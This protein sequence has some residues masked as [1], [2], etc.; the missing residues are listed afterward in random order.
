MKNRKLLVLALPLL[1]LAACN[2]TPGADDGGTSNAASDS[3]DTGDTGVSGDV[4]DSGEEVVYTFQDV[5]DAVKGNDFDSKVNTWSKSRVSEEA[6][7]TY[8]LGDDYASYNTSTQTYELD[9]KVYTNDVD[10]YTYI[11]DGQ[12]ISCLD[13]IRDDYYLQFE[14]TVDGIYIPSAYNGLLVDGYLT[15][16]YE[17][18]EDYDSLADIYFAGP[19][20][21][22]EF[23][24][25]VEE[26]LDESYDVDFKYDAVANTFSVDF[27]SSEEVGTID[28][29]VTGAPAAEFDRT[30]VEIY[31]VS[32]KGTLDGEVTF[33]EQTDFIASY[34]DGQ[35]GDELETP[36]VVFA[37]EIGYF[38]I[39]AV[40]LGA[41]EGELPMSA[42]AAREISYYGEW[43]SEDGKKLVMDIYNAQFL[44]DVYTLNEETG[45]Y[46]FTS[47]MYTVSTTGVPTGASWNSTASAYRSAGV[48]SGSTTYY[49]FFRLDADGNLEMIYGRSI[50]NVT[51]TVKFYRADNLPKPEG[52]EEGGD[53]GEGVGE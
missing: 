50:T 45:E 23:V 17:E 2:G 1:L 15:L 28:D 33:F 25:F 37:D 21:N 3:V 7:Y 22:A 41:Y 52:G 46:E 27:V 53:A 18:Y 5:C 12:S 14:K 9:H 39:D 34:V 19:G 42:Q 49:Y 43:Y 26:E 40:E 30:L 32:F 6:F 29:F 8:L 31:T 4:G 10:T 48:R 16:G 44:P 20:A 11:S 24:N 36:Y 35:T 51:S 47:S 13:Y 38:N